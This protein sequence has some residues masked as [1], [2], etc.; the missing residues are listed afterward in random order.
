MPNFGLNQEDLL[1]LANSVDT[2]INSAARVAHYGNYEIFYRINVSSV[3]YMID[4]CTN[5]NKK[6]YHISTISISGNSLETS[7][8]KQNLGT[9]KYFEEN[10]LYIGQ[11]LDNVYT[12][13][14]YKAECKVLD[15]IENGLDAYILRMGNLMPRFKDGKFQDNIS[16][17][18]FINRIISFIKIGAI[19]Q[20]IENNY[21]EFTPVDSAANA[22]IKLI[23]HPNTNHT[24]FHL[25]NHNHVYFKQ[26]LSIFDNFKY[27]IQIV[28]DS[29]F[30][31]KI[32]EILQ[33]DSK[34][35]ILNNLINDLDKD[36]QLIYETDIIVKSDYTI[37]YLDKIN[38][39]WPK[40]NQH[41]LINFLE[42]LRSVM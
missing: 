17:N 11:S 4:F 28:S 10:N 36:L 30:R 27:N 2:V 3:N 29:D 19:P 16:E 5:F 25:Y 33:D 21:L 12:Y 9:T 13:T 31:K 18:A 14:K 20:Y 35:F 1:N 24:I 6:F 37:N 15:A 40:I 23:T 34:K 38:F 41:Y 22:I 32:K 26:A 42:L 39:K 7:S 8:I